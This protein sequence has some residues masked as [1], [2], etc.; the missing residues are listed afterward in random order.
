MEWAAI[1]MGSSPARFK[2]STNRSSILWPCKSWCVELLG[3][4]G[5]A[6]GRTRMPADMEVVRASGCKTLS[7]PR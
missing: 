4:T 2:D 5:H 1:G 3:L 7:T 6:A